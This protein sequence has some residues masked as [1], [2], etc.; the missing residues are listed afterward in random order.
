MP[1]ETSTGHSLSLPFQVL[2]SFHLDAAQHDWSCKTHK[3]HP[4]QLAANNPATIWPLAETHRHTPQA[5]PE[6]LFRR[7]RRILSPH[8]WPVVTEPG[9]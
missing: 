8:L 2:E 7:F 1:F 5:Y 6:S 9:M 3:A 4:F